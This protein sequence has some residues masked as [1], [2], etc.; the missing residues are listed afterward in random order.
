MTYDS[1]IAGS[2]EA[3]SGCGVD[4]VAAALKVAAGASLTFLITR[5]VLEKFPSQWWTND[6]A[7]VVAALEAPGVFL[8]A[9]KDLAAGE[10]ENDFEERDDALRASR[11]AVRAGVVLN[12]LGVMDMMMC[13]RAEG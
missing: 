6:A 8:M 11:T 13:R 5:S 4:C 1:S 12:I 9:E 2:R 3:W 10:V 7:A